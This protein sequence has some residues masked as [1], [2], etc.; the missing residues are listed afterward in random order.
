MKFP[1]K[2]RNTVKASVAVRVS[3]VSLV[4]ACIISCEKENDFPDYNPPG[5]H[6]ISKDGIM[7]KSGLNQPLDNCIN[8]HGADLQGG[9][10]GVS[11]YECHGE[12]W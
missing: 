12:A 7:H 9:S 5:D 8:C 6:T 3:I 10:S 11:C 1:I 4:L 2:I